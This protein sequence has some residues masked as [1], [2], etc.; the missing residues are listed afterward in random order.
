MRSSLLDLL[1]LIGVALIAWALW[2][3]DTRIARVFLGLA[4]IVIAGMG[5]VTESVRARRSAGR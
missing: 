3:F 4:F 2:D 5:A 1:A